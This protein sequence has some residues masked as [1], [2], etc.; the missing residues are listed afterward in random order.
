MASGWRNQQWQL[1]RRRGP[2]PAA[3]RHRGQT[4]SSPAPA[5]GGRIYQL[6]LPAPAEVLCLAQLLPR[7]RCS[8]RL[9]FFPDIYGKEPWRV[10]GLE[11]GR[12]TER[13]WREMGKTVDWDASL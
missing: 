10:G 13:S 11:L 8:A 4:R 1:A 7:R 2:A 9:A 3:S 5:S 6:R 12:S